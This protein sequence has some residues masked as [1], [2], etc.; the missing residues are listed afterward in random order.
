MGQRLVVT[1]YGTDNERLANGYFHWSAYSDS[2]AEVLNNMV[3]VDGKAR[4]AATINGVLDEVLYAIKMF[5]FIGAGIHKDEIGTVQEKYPDI[6]FIEAQDRNDGLVAI[7]EDKMDDFMN[8]AEGTVE[9]NPITQTVFFNLYYTV[10][11]ETEDMFYE[12]GADDKFDFDPY[13]NDE[14]PEDVKDYMQ[15]WKKH[16]LLQ[17]LHFL[18]PS[19]IKTGLDT[20]KNFCQCLLT[21]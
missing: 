17:I 11:D 12:S 3:D 1:V 8:W 18:V 4:E 7:T 5:E 19:A 6:Q 13:C 16:F 20:V 2:A 10:E 14:Y 15:N 9:I 21:S